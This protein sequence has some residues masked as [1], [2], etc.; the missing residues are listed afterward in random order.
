MRHRSAK[1]LL[2]VALAAPLLLATAASAQT[3]PANP[4]LTMPNPTVGAA[5]TSG[6]WKPVTGSLPASGLISIP[7]PN[8]QFSELFFK[9]ENVPGRTD[10][11]K[12]TLDIPWLAQYISG[13]Y[14]Y[15]VGIAGVMAAVMMM[16]GGFQYLIAGGDATRVA[17]GK[18][19]ISDAVLGLVLVLGTYMILSVINPDLVSLSAMRIEAIKRVTFDAT[20]LSDLSDAATSAEAAGAAGSGGGTG[21]GGGAVSGATVCNSKESCKTWCE[22]HPDPSTWPTSTSMTGDYNS[23]TRIP[24]DVG[25]QNNARLTSDRGTTALVE[26][27]KRAGR[28]AVS[29]KPTYKLMVSSASRSLETQI[30]LACDKVKAGKLDDLGRTVAYP[31]GSNHGKGVAVDLTLWDGG[32]A[33]TTAGNATAQRN[34]RWTAGS[35]IL[36]QIMTEAGFQRYKVEI[37]HFEIGSSGGCRCTTCPWPPPTSCR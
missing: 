3:T 12:K 17:K 6:E 16:I 31:G 11:T 23:M 25:L 15:A 22:S 9:E 36:D 2:A 37:W 13:A 18:E 21:G 19:K 5:P 4:S 1:I 30:R 8:V 7:I 35:Q 27:L 26:G 10:A 14:K 34:D 28:I 24:N 29:K 32:T 33:L 20:E